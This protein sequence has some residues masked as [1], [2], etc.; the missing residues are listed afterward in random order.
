M[1]T[2]ITYS[3]GLAI[4]HASFFC[5]FRMF[6]SMTL[7]YNIVLNVLYVGLYI[8]YSVHFLCIRF[9]FKI[10][11]IALL[12]QITECVFIFRFIKLGCCKAS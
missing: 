3:F 5:S 6:L 12:S 11:V 9:F 2:S 7:Y 1:T 10:F 4:S 8:V